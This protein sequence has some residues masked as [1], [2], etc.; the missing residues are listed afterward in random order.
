[1]T[2][3]WFRCIGI[4]S[5]LLLLSFSIAA[6]HGQA[7]LFDESRYVEV[8]GSVKEWS[9]VNPHPVLLLEITGENGEPEEWDVYFGPAA[10]S[11][12]RRRGFLDDTFEVGEILLVKGRPATAAGARG[13]DVWRGDSIVTRADGSVVP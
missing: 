1:M 13:I 3:K 12:L 4:G 11:A 2:V 6:H 5:V 9:F 10:V 7:G 8:M